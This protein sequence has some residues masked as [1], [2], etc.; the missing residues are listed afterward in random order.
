MDTST[1]TIDDQVDLVLHKIALSPHLT[2]NLNQLYAVAVMNENTYHL[3]HFMLEK[4]LLKISG[5]N[6]TIT[7][8]GLEIANFGGWVS[9]QKQF[10]KERPR[11]L[12]GLETQQLK[13]DNEFA[14]MR[15]EI[16]KY[17]SELQAKNEKE[18]AASNIIIS[19]IE[20]NKNSKLMFFIGGIAVGILIAGVLSY[21]L[22]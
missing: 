22:F 12:F 13:Y 5:E 20:Q 6:R 9:Y 3:D 7:A 11:N 18:I 14:A 16:Q 10:K 2:L 17:K 19:L 4:G 1:L 21:V 15:R 8:K